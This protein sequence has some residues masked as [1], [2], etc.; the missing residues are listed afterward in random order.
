MQSCAVADSREFCCIISRMKTVTAVIFVLISFSLFAQQPGHQSKNVTL[1]PNGWKI[2]PAGRHLQ[3]DDLPMEMIESKDGSTMIITNNG[4]SKPVLSVIDLEHFYVRDRVRVDDAWLGLEWNP[5]GTKLYSSAAAAGAIDVFNFEKG[6]LK[7]TASIP[8]T[9]ERKESF[10]GGISLTPDGKRLYAVQVLGNLLS[11]VDTESQKETATLPLDAEPYG[12]LMAEDGKTLFVSLWGGARVLE[13][14]T[15]SNSIRREIVVGEHP[16]SMVLSQDGHRLFVACAST[17]SVWGIDLREG[18]AVE[19]VSV[20]LYPQAPA[21]STPTGLGLSPD[22]NTLL[23]AASDNNCVAVV[24]ISHPGSSR[25]TGFI[26]TGWYPT[27]ARYSR[28]GKRIYVLSGKGLTSGPNPRGGDEPNYVA[29]LLLGTLSAIDVPDDKQL[30]S[31]TKTVYDLTPYSDSVRLTP[32]RV[33]KHSPIPSKVGA[34]SPLKHVFYI[35]RENRTYDQVLGDLS[36]GNGDANLCL[37]CGEVTPN[38]HALAQQFVLLD[39]FYVDAEVSADGHSFSMGGYANDFIEK[40]WPMNYA[41]RGGRYLT[42]GGGEN[43]NAYGNIAAPPAGYLWDAAKRAGVSVR[44]YG[45]FGRRSEDEDDDPGHGEVKAGVPGLEG[46]I[47]PNYAPWNLKIPDSER[48]AVWIEEFH[49][50]EQS[51]SLPQLSILYLPQDHTH[52]THPGYP[53]PR[54]MVAEN[55]EAL[56][57]VVEVISHSRFWKESAIFV[58]EDDAQDGPDHVDAHRSVGLIISPYTKRGVV[59]STMLTTCGFLR[60]MELILG[61]EPMSQYDAAATP[62]FNSFQEKPNTKPFDRIPAQVRLDDLNAASV[63]GAAESMAMD[64]SEPDR[65]PM[66]ILNEVLWTSIR[67][68]TMPPPVHAAF[69]RPIEEQ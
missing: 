46:I 63:Y 22:G 49:Q 47:N 52:G 12:T 20:A 35:I 21:G 31:Y 25:V 59:D 1:L 3:L 67:G 48:V 37:F 61:I 39:N 60:T 10:V 41:G 33:P 53:T 4:Y 28:D 40:T 68:T 38:A 5:D 30:A 64:F 36:Q 58:L 23:V 26:P 2:A 15:E 44:S 14:D 9:H 55:D 19:Q 17:N 54:A 50:F 57:R 11:V 18:K 62:A 42:S 8:V 27:A 51:N 69:L 24:D 34:P 16:N 65:I 43:R 66:R 7:K 45:E 29:Q 32:A 56:G 13:I 6:A